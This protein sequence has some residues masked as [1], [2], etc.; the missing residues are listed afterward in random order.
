MKT[1]H[2]KLAATLMA[3][4]SAAMLAGCGGS[5][6]TTKQAPVAKAA[7]PAAQSPAPKADKPTPPPPPPAAPAAAPVAPAPPPAP[8]AAASGAFSDPEFETMA[9]LLTGSWKS[10]NGVAT[11]DSSTDVFFSL[12]PVAMTGVPDAMYAELARADSIDV[13]FRQV[14]LQFHK[15]NGKVHLRTMEFKRPKGEVISIRALWVLPEVF[16]A[17]L[18]DADLQATTDMVFAKNGGT[19]HGVSSAPVASAIGGAM[20]VTSE[21]ELMAGELKLAD[22]GLAADGSVVWGPAKGAWTTFTR[23]STGMTVT[24]LGQ[25]L[26][27]INYPS[28][29]QPEPTPK[30]DDIISTQYVGTVGNGTI[31]DASYTRGT[32]FRYTYDEPLMDGW[33]RAMSDVRVGMKRKLVIPG[34]MAWGEKGNPRRNIGPNATLFFQLEVLGIT[35]APKKAPLPPVEVKPDDVDQKQQEELKL[36]TDALN[37]KKPDHPPH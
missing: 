15:E 10:A 34:P 23:A 12:A 21:I 4:V 20:Q 18:T 11:G 32:P 9:K 30:N 19:Y 17:E 3:G 5:A 22:R 8:A 35:E 24:T 27:I 2:W 25:G 14:I 1:S 13:P 6:Q 28:N 16:P 31:F 36:K 7:A 33:R 29:I 26:F 37:E